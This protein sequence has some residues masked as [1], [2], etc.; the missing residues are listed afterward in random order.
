M[1]SGRH[2]ARAVRGINVTRSLLSELRR[3][4]GIC[5]T[6]SAGYIHKK[7]WVRSHHLQKSCHATSITETNRLSSGI[8]C[9]CS[10]GSSFV[11]S[12]SIQICENTP[13][14]VKNSFHGKFCHSWGISIC[15]FSDPKKERVSERGRKKDLSVRDECDDEMRWDVLARVGYLS[16]LSQPS[17]FNS[18]DSSRFPVHYSIPFILIFSSLNPRLFH[19]TNLHAF[20]LLPA[21]HC[22]CCCC[23]VKTLENYLSK[24]ERSWVVKWEKKRLNY[25]WE[26]TKGKS[27]CT[28]KQVE[29][30][31]DEIIAFP[32]SKQSFSFCYSTTHRV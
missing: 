2:N 8:L 4:S 3:V 27:A 32:H 21:L 9:V 10:D 13:L 26:F 20:L 1:C 7:M 12:R 5:W 11:A 19:F 31:E 18:N 14:P 17:Q 16:E 23:L 29:W 15:L 25:E 6:L 22:R 30:E 24:G 28:Q